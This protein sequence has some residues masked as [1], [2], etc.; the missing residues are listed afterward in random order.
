MKDVEDMKVG[1]KVKFTYDM[2]AYARI[3]NVEG[4]VRTI[5]I[6]VATSNPYVGR[7]IY[8]HNIDNVEIIK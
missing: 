2:G 7:D 6:I 5:K 1:Q 3:S 4:V 8:P